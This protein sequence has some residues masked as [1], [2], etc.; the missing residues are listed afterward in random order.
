[1]LL[2]YALLVG[3]TPYA[4]QHLTVGTIALTLLAAG[5]TAAGS[6]LTLLGMRRRLSHDADVAGRRAFIAGLAAFGLAITARPF[7]P[8]INPVGQYVVLG[9]S[10]ALLTAAMFFPWLQSSGPTPASRGE[11]SAE[12]P[13]LFDGSAAHVKADRT[14][15]EA[16]HNA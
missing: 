16:R 2:G 15:V 1:V 8:F 5:A 4:R 9:I 14:A 7:L 3:V 13:S 6:A 10:G 12:P 11:R